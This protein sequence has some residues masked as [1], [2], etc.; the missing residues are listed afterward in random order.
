M[1]VICAIFTGII[2]AAAVGAAEWLPRRGA[3][4]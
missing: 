3:R 1:S 2:A 4:G